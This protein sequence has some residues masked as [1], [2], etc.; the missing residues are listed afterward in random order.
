M[1]NKLKIT[2]I[3]VLALIFGLVLFATVIYLLYVM[4]KE[5]NQAPILGILISIP[6]ALVSF[7]FIFTYAKNTIANDLLIWLG[8]EE[9]EENRNFVKTLQD[10]VWKVFVLVFVLAYVYKVMGQ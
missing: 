10:G 9:N 8:V 7:Y 1:K 2:S 3:F 5:S 4:I 6:I